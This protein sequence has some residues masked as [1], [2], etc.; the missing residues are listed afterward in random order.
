VPSH[1]RIRPQRSS[2]VG[3]C[4][5]D[6]MPNKPV[7]ELRLHGMRGFGRVIFRRPYPDIQVRAAELPLRQGLSIPASSSDSGVCLVQ[8]QRAE[9]LICPIT[10]TRRQCARRR[11][12]PGSRGRQIDLPHKYFPRDDTKLAPPVR[13]VPTAIS[14]FRQ[15]AQAVTII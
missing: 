14:S 4:I 13:G 15:L 12:S 5:L 11:I 9:R 10:G 2:A 1:D 8:D 3:L 7:T 6:L